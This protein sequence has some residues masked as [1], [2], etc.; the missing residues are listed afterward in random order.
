MLDEVLSVSVVCGEVRLHR[1][2]CW[3]TL[4]EVE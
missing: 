4:E 3:W 2:R 1:R